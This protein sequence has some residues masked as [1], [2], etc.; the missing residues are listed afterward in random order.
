MGSKM[1]ARVQLESCSC[2]NRTADEQ[3]WESGSMMKCIQT[4]FSA[5]ISTSQGSHSQSCSSGIHSEE[6]QHV[7]V[8]SSRCAFL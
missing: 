7:K 1:V 5:Y 2:R 4:M 3:M 8:K 6:Y